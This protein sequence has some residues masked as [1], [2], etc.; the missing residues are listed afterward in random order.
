MI[1]AL[2]IFLIINT[3]FM[4]AGFLLTFLFMKHVDKRFDSV[5]KSFSHLEESLNKLG[6]RM[7][8][9]ERALGLD[10]TTYDHKPVKQNSKSREIN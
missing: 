3:L 1:I 5:L 8:H 10:I 9:L 7:S 2:L 4:L 6:E